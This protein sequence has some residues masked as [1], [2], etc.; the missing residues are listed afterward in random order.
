MPIDSIGCLTVVSGG[1]V[2]FMNAESSYPTTDTSPGT[3]RPA[4]RT[5]RIAPS[6][7]TSLAQMI[8]VTPCRSSRAGLE[9]PFG[10]SPPDASASPWLPQPKEWR[11]LTVELQ[12]GDPDSM[13][14]LYRAALRLR[15]AEPALGDGPMRW[16]PSPDG[17]LAFGRGDLCC[18]ANLSPAP[19]ALPARTAV[20]LASGPLDDDLLPPDTAVWLRTS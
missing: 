18:V 9:P 17:V 1:S 4:R 11:E 19:V 15:R 10:F 14:E 3:D 12:A 6:A 13:L 20:L 5:A 7:S 2:Q 8:P 16:L